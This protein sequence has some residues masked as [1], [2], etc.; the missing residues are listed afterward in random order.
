MEEEGAHEGLSNGDIRGKIEWT[1]GKEAFQTEGQTSWDLPTSSHWLP[2]L[3][4]IPAAEWRVFLRAVSPPDQALS[5]EAGSS[6]PQLHSAQHCAC[7][8]VGNQEI[9]HDS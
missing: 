5:P 3:G 7:H 8:T 4:Q 6:Q 2:D 1:R 9:F